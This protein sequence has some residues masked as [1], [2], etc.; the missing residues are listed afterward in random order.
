MSASRRGEVRDALHALY[1]G[2]ARARLR[3]EDAQKVDELAALLPEIERGLGRA[4]DALLV[5][6][7]AGKAAVG[8]IAARLLGGR[9]RGTLRVLVLERAPDRAAAA[10]RAVAALVTT[11]A[12]EVEVREGDVGDPA[13]WPDAPALVVALHACGGASDAIIA[14]ACAA[15]ARRIL[16]VP[17]CYAAATRSHAAARIGIPRHALVARRFSQALIDA[18]RTLRLEAA[19]YQTEVVE[20]VSP[21]VTPFNLLWRARRVREPRRMAEAVTR[22]ELLAAAVRDWD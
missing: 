22:L 9:R 6:A 7:A 20:L 18:E 19:G 16:L 2:A 4:G 1:I 17:C 5:D 14:R 10:R 13:L 8:L 12:A 3:E 21:R 11:T 15:R